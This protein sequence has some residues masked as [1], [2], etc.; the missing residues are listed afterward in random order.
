MWGGTRTYR[1]G[2]LLANWA[3]E[4]DLRLCNAG[5]APTCT[6]PQGT[7]VIDLT[8]AR[9][10]ENSRISEWTV[11]DTE[12]MSDHA[13]ISYTYSS[14]ND[15]G[16][17]LARVK[18]PRWNNEEFDAELFNATVDLECSSLWDGDLPTDHLAGKLNGIIVDGC[19][20]AFRR[21]GRRPPRKS[22]YWWNREI[23]VVRAL[24]TR[25]RRRLTRLRRR[26]PSPERNRAELE[27]RAAKRA[28]KAIRDSKSKA[29][30][31]LIT[32]VNKDPWGLPFKLVMNRLRCTTPSITETL[33]GGVLDRLLDELF[34]NGE[35]HDPREIWGNGRA[36]P[37]KQK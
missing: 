13:Y 24:C 29:W 10:H 5:D 8:W 34:P 9:L 23:E 2:A 3:A 15:E 17:D 31:E 1:R 6:R 26:G 37:R 11:V 16:D 36:S 22:A 7:S 4:L 14:R 35:T 20:V 28:L 30:R 18:Y 19:D 27:Y 33:E 21:I 12:T 32:T 25:A